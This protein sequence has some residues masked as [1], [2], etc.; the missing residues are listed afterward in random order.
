MRKLDRRQALLSIGAAGVGLA[1]GAVPEFL[2]GTDAT[3][4]PRHV[5][6][7]AHTLPPDPG[8]THG[9]PLQAL[10]RPIHNLHDLQPAAPPNAVALTIDDGPHP[11]WTPKMLDLLAE[12]DVP[13]T[14]SLIGTQVTEDPRLVQRLVAGGHQVS[15]HTVTHPLNLPHLTASRIREEIGGAHDRIAQVTGVAPKF[16][17]SPGGA[18][19]QQIIDIAAEHSMICIDWQVDPRD[20]ARPGTTRITDQLLRAQAGDIL[21]CHDGGGDRSET[22]RS[23]RT[24]IPA[25]KQRGLTFVAL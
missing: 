24:V 6:K 2:R 1:A 23:L 9:R 20:W 18:W 8:Y 25:L 3:T 5:R 4:T 15:D 21:L 16:F 10:R 7:A 12:F 19:S 13:A 22:I 17:R 11:V 14:F